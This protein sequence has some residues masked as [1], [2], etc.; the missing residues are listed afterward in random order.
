[1][2]DL[3]HLIPSERELLKMAEAIPAWPYFILTKEQADA[4]RKSTQAFRTDIPA[5]L[6]E[7]DRLRSELEGKSRMIQAQAGLR[8][9]LQRRADLYED[10]RERVEEADS[11]PYE[12]Q[13]PEVCA[14]AEA[15]DVGRP[16]IDSGT[17]MEAARDALNRLA[18]AGFI[19]VARAAL[20]PK[21][22]EGKG[23]GP[24]PIS[25]VASDHHEF[26]APK[27]V[28]FCGVCNNKRDH[29]IHRISSG[30]QDGRALD[31]DEVNRL[32]SEVAL[33]RYELGLKPIHSLRTCVTTLYQKGRARMDE[34]RGPL[35]EYAMEWA[36]HFRAK[37]GLSRRAAPA[38]QGSTIFAVK[39]A[40]RLQEW[41]DGRHG[42][43]LPDAMYCAGSNQFARDVLA[44]LSEI[45]RL[46][47]EIG[48]LT[49]ERDEALAANLLLKGANQEISGFLDDASTRA[50]TAE[51]ALAKAQKIGS[52]A[53]MAALRLLHA[54]EWSDGD[55]ELEPINSAL[56]A[57]KGKL[58]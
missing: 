35:C 40:A 25:P 47:A 17:F 45:D 6:K 4:A 7:V 3:P 33:I 26:T 48:R 21:T 36:D 14:I 52:D 31:L 46:T 9:D 56:T 53:L 38:V 44:V 37:S 12:P 13:G 18:K 2:I 10:I 55:P 58:T 51:D 32:V 19:V 34:L 27:G 30:A 41:R 11:A 28:D 1:M 42:E 43:A 24:S 23:A 57:L 39:A 15:I 16:Y 54:G 29:P 22:A 50:E 8:A 49:R 5:L 20:A